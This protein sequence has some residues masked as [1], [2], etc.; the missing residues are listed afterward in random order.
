VYYVSVDGVLVHNA[1][2]GKA[3][4]SG[5]QANKAAGD[6]V[7]D[8]IAAREEMALVEQSFS[9]VGGM[10]RVDVLKLGQELISIESKVGRTALDARVRQELARDWWLRRQG[11]VDRV[12]WEFSPSDVTGKVGPSKPLLEMLNKLGF[13]VRINTP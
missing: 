9:T 3:V 11:Q 6:A 12:V 4:D 5:V 8:L 10:R 2:G 7:R 1:Y 13:E